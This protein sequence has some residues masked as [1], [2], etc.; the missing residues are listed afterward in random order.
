VNRDDGTAEIPV[1][2][3]QQAVEKAYAQAEHNKQP[4]FGIEQYEEGY[5]VTYDLLPAGK[6]LAPTARK[7]LQVQLTNEIET[8]VANESLST[9]EVSKS[10]SESLG[11]ISFLASEE[12][13]KQVAQVIKPI[14]LD[15][16]NWTKHSDGNELRR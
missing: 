12:S 4:F 7:E 8:I 13:A 16:A 11:N 5:A 10:I 1:Y 2:D 6:Q 3:G 9:I 14:V 15:E